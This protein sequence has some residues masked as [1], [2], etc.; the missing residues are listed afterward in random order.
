MMRVSRNATAA[1]RHAS[2]H[3]AEVRGSRLCGCFYCLET[4]PPSDIAE[5]VGRPA[6]TALC[7]K[8]G[9]DSVIGSRSGYPVGDRG[10]LRRMC[11][12]WFNLRRP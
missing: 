4:F 7:P 8:C 10:F 9:I 12:R 6:D 11:E 3:K 1:H 2:H 5:W